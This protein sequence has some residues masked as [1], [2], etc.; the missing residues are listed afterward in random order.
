METVALKCTK[1]ELLMKVIADVVGNKIF[2][3]C[4]NIECE[5]FTNTYVLENSTFWM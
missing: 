5:Q 2:C 1:C 4:Q 3:Q